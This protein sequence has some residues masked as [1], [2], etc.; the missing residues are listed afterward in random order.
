ML[1]SPEKNIEHTRTRLACAGDALQNLK[2][3]RGPSG[4]LDILNEIQFLEHFVKWSQGYLYMELIVDFSDTIA[5]ISKCLNYKVCGGKDL[6]Y[7]SEKED[8][9]II[10][11]IY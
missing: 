2:L 6:I 7:F 11:G 1:L 10:Q 4:I 3:L 5:S 9:V 8:W